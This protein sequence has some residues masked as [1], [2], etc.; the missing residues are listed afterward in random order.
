MVSFFRE[1]LTMTTTK[2]YLIVPL[3][4]MSILI[5]SGCGGA[6][7]AEITDVQIGSAEELYAA[8]LRSEVDSLVQAF[9][10]EGAGIGGLKAHMEGGA[11]NIEFMASELEQKAGKYKE[12]CTKIFDEI[13]QLT[14]MLNG[15]PKREQVI[16]KLDALQKLA[17]QLP[18]SAIQSKDGAAPGA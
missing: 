1:L 6:G 4:L 16:A 11:E 12:T 15:S 9:R 3:G 13:H 5:A 10:D 17:G 2:A 14:D 8:G 7:P 18:A